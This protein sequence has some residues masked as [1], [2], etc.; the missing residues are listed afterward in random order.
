[1][2]NAHRCNFVERLNRL[3]LLNPEPIWVVIGPHLALAR[4]ENT[5]GFHRAYFFDAKG[6]NPRSK[7]SEIAPPRYHLNSAELLGF[8]FSLTYC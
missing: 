8:I 6:V 5:T 3:N 7:S 2:K 1:M 4:L